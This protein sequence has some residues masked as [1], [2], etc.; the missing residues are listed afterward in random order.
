MKG[1]GGP[2]AILNT[3]R[4]RIFAV[5]TAGSAVSLVGMWM[6]RVAVGWLMWELTG[7]GTWLGLAA[8]ADLFPT[9]FTAPFAGAAADR[10][11][12][13]SVSR[14]T[15]SLAMV[16]AFSLFLLTATGHIT[17]VLLFLLTAVG[18]VL[19][20]FNQ[21]ARL[22]LITSLVPRSEIVPAVGVNAIVFNLARFVGPALGGALIVTWGISATFLANAV[23]YL[24]FLYALG[25]IGKLPPEGPPAKRGSFAAELV[26]GLR[27]VVR[28]RGVGLLLLLSVITSIGSRPAIELLPGFSA[29]V[30]EAGAEGLA[31]L[32]SAVGI[33]AIL[34]GFWIGGRADARGLTGV[35]LFYSLALS[36]AFLLFT[37]TTNLWVAALV[38]GA[39]G[40]C[41]S[42]SG[43]A[44]QTLVQL[45][46]PSAMRGRVLSIYG[47]IFRGCP[48]LGALLMG[49]AAE[50]LGFR[51]PVLVGS[52]LAGLA[53]LAF[54]VK[55]DRVARLLE[56]DEPEGP[57]PRAV[58]G[59]DPGN[60]NDDPC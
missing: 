36:L 1:S 21:P 11:D 24:V 26:E 59:V 44:S 27:Y 20:A 14:V 4:I 38:L 22:A 10:W 16:Q 46:V 52:V 5:Y 42:C 33:G 53:C 51:A 23:S 3:L 60:R 28:D 47:L 31:I 25:R 12:R 2:R 34:G 9:F 43:I 58:P 15:Q 6:Q 55:R 8:F 37:A 19:A 57:N 39:T 17:P 48:A 41:M 35:A 49:S 30:F 7:S 45:S 18:G 54:L 56:R 32:T 40:F 29:A 13:L 50:R